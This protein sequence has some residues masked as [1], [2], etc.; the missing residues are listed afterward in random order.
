MAG[1]H[2]A[3]A[4]VPKEN[5]PQPQAPQDLSAPEAKTE[6]PEEVRPKQQRLPDNAPVPE[7]SVR[8]LG[9]YG[10]PGP[11]FAPPPT[12]PVSEAIHRPLEPKH[13]SAFEMGF[14]RNP[15]Y[16]DPALQPAPK[17]QPEP[18]RGWD[19]GPKQVRIIG[20]SPSMAG[21]VNTV[22]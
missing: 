4:E 19:G 8:M 22:F 11:A 17:A 1:G 7:G 13:A 3:A 14:R 9:G 12:Q 18:G 10:E 21:K 2:K 6:V 15:D 20:A 16:P 5:P